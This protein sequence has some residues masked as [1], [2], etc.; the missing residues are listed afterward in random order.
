MPVKLHTCPFPNFKYAHP[1]WRV[2]EALRDAGVEYEIVKHSM[3]RGRR[4]E[5]EQLSG[6]KVLPVIEFEDGSAYR[7]ESAA[8]A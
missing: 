8:M 4:P 1:C 3:L 5:V 2:Q 6:Q 7:D